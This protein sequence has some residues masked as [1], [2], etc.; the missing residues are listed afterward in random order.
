MF[1]KCGRDGWEKQEYENK[2][3]NGSGCGMHREK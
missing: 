1:Y 2:Q 3:R